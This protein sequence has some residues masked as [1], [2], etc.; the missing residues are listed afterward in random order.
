MG[1][2]LLPGWEFSPHL[3]GFAAKRVTWESLQMVWKEVTPSQNG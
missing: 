3:L 1:V 2:N